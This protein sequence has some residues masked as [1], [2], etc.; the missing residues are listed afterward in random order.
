[1]NT[2]FKNYYPTPKSVIR[3]MVGE[4]EHKKEHDSIRIL[5]PSAGKGH[6]LDYI[7][8]NMQYRDVKL[9]CIEQEPEFQLILREK[10][11]HFLDNDFLTFSPDCTFDYIIMNPPFDNG[12]KHFLKAW[13]IAS[14]TEICC[15][16]N[17]EDINNLNTA[18]KKLLK[19]ILEDNN[20]SVEHLGDCFRDSERVTG[21]NVAM[22]RVTRKNQSEYSYEFTKHFDQEKKFSINDIDNTA[23]ANRDVFGN[24]EIRYNKIRECFKRLI[25]VKKEMEHYSSDLLDIN[26]VNLFAKENMSDIE[27]FNNACDSIRENAWK[28]VFDNTKL[29]NV[30]TTNIQK[31]IADLQSKQ[32]H[33]AFTAKNMENMYMDLFQN[34][35]NIMKD[36]IVESFDLLTKYYKENRCHVEGWKT[37]ER[38]Y[39]NK[40]FILPMSVDPTWS[41]FS[42]YVHL[43]YERGRELVDI[44][45]AMCF[46]TNQ[47]I[48]DIETI[49]AIF[50]N[51]KVTEYGKWYDSTFFEFKAFKKGT[52]HFKFKSEELWAKFNVTACEGKNWI[53]F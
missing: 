28:N 42:D 1:M 11:Y 32:G 7:S 12:I 41:R 27:I 14:D 2:Q 24:M 48:E 40:K 5:E 23:I 44:E 15:L 52:M 4:I 25:E 6:I 9:F 34:M 16:L 8:E 18:P 21:V 39:I 26:L 37:N 13:E 50:H 38:F 29:R 19:K 17:A 35:N 30:V 33:M 46:L 22:V 20:G 47:K 49:D 53:G 3:K 43:N 45:K 10:D 36:C 51:K 31:K